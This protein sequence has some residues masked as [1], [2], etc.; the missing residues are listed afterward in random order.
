[1]IVHERVALSELQLPLF[2]KRKNQKNLLTSASS[3]LLSID[4]SVH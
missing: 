2:N 1:M 4:Q 3:F